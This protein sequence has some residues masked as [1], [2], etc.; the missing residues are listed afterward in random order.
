MQQYLE[1]TKA[2]SAAKLLIQ[3]AARY[4]QTRLVNRKK[5]YFIRRII[6]F[7]PSAIVIHPE[8]RP[9]AY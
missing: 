2:V 5:S 4:K 9:P 7:H 8:F 6:A 3:G 1:E